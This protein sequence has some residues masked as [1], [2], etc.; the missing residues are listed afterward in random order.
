M[1][2]KCET[3]C[4]TV[5]VYRLLFTLGLLICTCVAIEIPQRNLSDASLGNVRS[6]KPGAG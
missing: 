6:E 4:N 2:E 5:V 1:G 3:N